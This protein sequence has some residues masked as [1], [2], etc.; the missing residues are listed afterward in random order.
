MTTLTEPFRIMYHDVP[1]SPWLNTD[2]QKKEKIEKSYM[3]LSN[4]GFANTDALI[5]L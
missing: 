3:I 4:L 1:S 5:Y 2:R